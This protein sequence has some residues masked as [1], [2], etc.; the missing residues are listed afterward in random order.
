MT[1]AL[2]HLAFLVLLVSSAPTLAQASGAADQPSG[3][4]ASPR[5]TL[6]H[7]LVFLDPAHGG[8]DAGAH[9]SAHAPELLLEK[10]I[11]ASLA[12]RLRFQLSSLGLATLMSRE[13]AAPGAQP[14]QAPA[15]PQTPK[16]IAAIDPSAD[17]RAGAANHVHPFAC[18][19][20][21]ATDTGSG[22]HLVTSAVTLPPSSSPAA[23]DIATAP[24]PTLTPWESA[25][26]ASL[27]QSQRL[28]AELA[29]A[30]SR[31]GLPVHQSRASIRPLDNLTCPAVLVELAPLSSA[32]VADSGYQARVAQAISTALLFWRGHAEPGAE[33]NGTAQP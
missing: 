20:L 9:L 31:A 17:Q 1:V 2:R 32:S 23:L 5:S 16:E 28:A 15:S 3:A 26:A 11:T 27:P 8:D 25:Q 33:T 14:P 19:V 18:I 21:H 4:P 10:D 13:D 30:L 29:T 22:V 6:N 12:N 24:S 7:S